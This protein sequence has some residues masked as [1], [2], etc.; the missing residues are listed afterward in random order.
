MKNDSST[1]LLP[2]LRY[3]RFLK[4][5]PAVAARFLEFCRMA[6]IAAVFRPAPRRMAWANSSVIRSPGS[7]VSVSITSLAPV[8]PAIFATCPFD[9]LCPLRAVISRCTP[10]FDRQLGFLFGDH[11]RV[12]E[13][14]HPRLDRRPV[15]SR[16]DGFHERLAVGDHDHRAERTGPL[17]E[18]GKGLRRNVRKFDARA[19]P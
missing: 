11:A 2:V 10:F 3:C 12:R 16:V 13:D 19:V 6:A 7:W 18:F 15:R 8:S 9:R 1:I 5:A 14:V 17:G 4:A